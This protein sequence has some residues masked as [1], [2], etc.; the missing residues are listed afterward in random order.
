[1]QKSFR[2]FNDIICKGT[3]PSMHEAIVGIKRS[4]ETILGSMESMVE[5][6]LD[7]YKH[8]IFSPMFDNTRAWITSSC[9]L[10]FGLKEEYG[11]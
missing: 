5:V 9:E 6:P 2:V 7:V 1:M 10:I 3:A 11:K 4:L 8:L